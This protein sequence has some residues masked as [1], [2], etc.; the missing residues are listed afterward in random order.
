MAGGEQLHLKLPAEADNI[1]VVREAVGTR[2]KEFGLEESAVDDLK[3]VVSEACAN[4]VL[5]A[6][7]DGARQRPLE[8]EMSQTE[9]AVN[10]V[11]RD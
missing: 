9:R 7:P 3:T 10:V 1:A 8:V 11:V 4:V 2:A 6:Y 5:H